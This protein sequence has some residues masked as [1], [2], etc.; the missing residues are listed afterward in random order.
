MWVELLSVSETE[1]DVKYPR[2]I[3]AEKSPPPQL[4]IIETN[5]EDL[6]FDE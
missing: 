5:I 3:K 4:L 6:D 1:E 2:I